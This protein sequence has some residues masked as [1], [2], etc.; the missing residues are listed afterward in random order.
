[1]MFSSA[2]RSRTRSAALALVVASTLAIAAS[3]VASSVWY[4][5]PGPTGRPTTLEL[6]VN[7]DGTVAGR[8]YEAPAQAGERPG[9]DI[10]FEGIATRDATLIRVDAVAVGSGVPPEG[11][12]LRIVADSVPRR[13]G[14][15]AEP[16]PLG[17]ALLSFV[18]SAGPAWRASLPAIAIGVR[19]QTTLDDGTLEVSAFG[20]FFY[21]DPWSDLQIAPDPTD[22]AESVL[23]GLEQRSANP[24]TASGIWW[25]ERKVRVEALTPRLTSVRLTFFSYTGGAHP[26]TWF[27]FATWL[28]SDDAWRSVD[29][30]G[31]LRALDYACDPVALRTTIVLDLLGQQAAWVVDASVD[32]T[33]PWLLDPFTV[34]VDGLRFD[35]AP[36]DVGPYAQGPFTVLVPFSSLPAR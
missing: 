15:L 25:D 29:V 3:A 17:N 35:Y 2:D 5:G 4:A 30:C 36:Y 27:A 16:D 22:L 20:P 28:R 19:S 24:A 21:A 6:T 34:T 14:G 23:T 31:A 33:A 18:P 10:V 9:L 7:D 26:N 13:G 32:A 8:V 12:K 11:V 1:M